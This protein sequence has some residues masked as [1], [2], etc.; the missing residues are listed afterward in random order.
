MGLEP[1]I[2]G[3]WVLQGIAGAI[4]VVRSALHRRWFAAT[5]IVVGLAI[6]SMPFLVIRGPA[7]WQPVILI[8]I[9][10]IIALTLVYSITKQ[11]KRLVLVSL[12]LVL[13]LSYRIFFLG[14]R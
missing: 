14:V 8:V 2:L 11:W 10:S 13:P 12:L 7:V 3:L 9:L 1:L 6:G 5:A 4:L